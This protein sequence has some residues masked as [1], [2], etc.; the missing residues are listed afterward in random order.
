MAE[1]AFIAVVDLETTGF[2]PPEHAPVEIGWCRLV[3]G[4]DLLGEPD[5]RRAAVTAPAAV[6]LNPGRKIPAEASAIHHLVDSDLHAA[7]D[8][9]V[10]VTL[11]AF[12]CYEATAFAA[13]SAGFEQKWLTPGALGVTAGA[14]P[15]IDTWK[16]ALR[17]LPDAPGH[18]NQCLRYHLRP[19]GLD[20]ALA[21]PAHRAGPDAYA[22]GFLLRELLQRYEL[23]TLLLWS[24]EP[25]ILIRV[26]FGK[27]PEEGGYRG[28]RWSEVD[29][30]FL[31]WVA[32]R[33]FSEDILHTVRVEMA[34]REDERG[35][36]APEPEGGRA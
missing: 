18:S 9:L 34:R 27:R 30:G 11:F 6:L 25:A 22:T 13:H 20:R 10:G 8:W 28:V 36:R 15:W 23:A 32:G 21:T 3:A 19:E 2:D 7:R 14:R 16:C 24:A 17:G 4:V 5:W 1:A 12:A 33:D 35:K 31:A 26:P 29:D